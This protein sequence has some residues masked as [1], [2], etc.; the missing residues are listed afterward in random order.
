MKQ[1]WFSSYGNGFEIYNAYRRTGLP[2]NIQDH[3]E[4]TVRG[5]PL[6]LPYPQSELTL[7]PNAA[8]YK[9]VAFDKTPIFWDK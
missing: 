5:F 4:G 7:N 3:V 8:S 6:R 1:L 2:T 9:D